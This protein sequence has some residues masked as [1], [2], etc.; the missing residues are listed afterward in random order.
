[1]RKS[2]A[3]FISIMIIVLSISSASAVTSTADEISAAE[4]IKV[5]DANGSGKI[6]VD[7]V[8]AIQKHLANMSNKIFYKS[9]AD[10]NYD[11]KISIDDVSLLQ[12][13][14][15]G[16]I[17][18]YSNGYYDV[19]RKNRKCSLINYHGTSSSVT[20][21]ST[22]NGCSVTEIMS[23]SFQNNSHIVTVTVPKTLIKIDDYAFYNC[24]NLTKM[25][26][27]N[28][29]MKWG[30]SFVECPKFKIMTLE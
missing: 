23:Y 28:K 20:I 12:K 9:K 8:T 4:G 5:G 14:I 21:P 7:D 19:D 29:N 1:M 18:E 16:L 24:K 25:I 22:V 26:Y 11:G 17:V 13:S 10:Y 6:T 15:S 30:Y 2:I 27:K 3:L